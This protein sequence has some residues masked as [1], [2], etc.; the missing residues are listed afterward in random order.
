MNCI[1]THELT[2]S[3]R[4]STV[5]TVGNHAVHG[6]RDPI[7][8]CIGA[9]GPAIQVPLGAVAGANA[10]THGALDP[11]YNRNNRKDGGSPANHQVEGKNDGNQAQGGHRKRDKA[12][13][14]LRKL[15][16]VAGALVGLGSLCERVVE[17]V[18]ENN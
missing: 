14:T 7:L 15:L 12:K 10:S 9:V 16:P 1:G 4:S 18:L 11:S 3:H 13:A 6:R 5:P 8:S 2:N 17:F